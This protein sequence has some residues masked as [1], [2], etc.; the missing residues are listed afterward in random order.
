MFV[1]I[2]W[3]FYSFALTDL[4]IPHLDN[5]IA[6][7]RDFRIVRDLDDGGALFAV[8]LANQFDDFLACFC[9]QLPV[10]SS[11]KFSDGLLTSALAIATRWRSP[12]DSSEG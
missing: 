8:Y 11:A 4:P 5:H 1:G 10:G 12:P 2:G 6:D 9:V 3:Y 7:R